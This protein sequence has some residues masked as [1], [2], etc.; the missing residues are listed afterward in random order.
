MHS[1]HGCQA[2][3]LDADHVKIKRSWKA[4]E[5]D[6]GDKY[7]ARCKLYY[8]IVHKYTNQLRLH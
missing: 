8:N 3:H 2:S 4:Q 7:L 1:I 5:K 6:I